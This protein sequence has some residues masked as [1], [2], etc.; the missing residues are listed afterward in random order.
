MAAWSLGATL[1]PTMEGATTLLEERDAALGLTSVQA[2]RILAEVGP[3][4]L[5]EAKR[6]SRIGRFAAQLV[7]LFALLLWAGAG[8]AWLAG[9]PQLSAAIVVVVLVNAIFAFAQEYRAE[10][11]AEALGRMLPQTARVRRDGDVVLL[12]AEEL[13]PGD[14][15]LLEAGDRVSADADLLDV[16]ELRVDNSTLT[17]ESWPVAPEE[18]VFAGTFVVSGR[19]E[20]RVTATGMSTKLGRIAELTQ[21]SRRKQS[22]LELELKRVTRLVA[23]VSAGI[24]TTFFVVAGFLGMGLEER[25]VFAVGVMVAN[26]PEG[27]LPTV[28]LALA[29]ATQRM[30][31]QNALI[32][33]LSSV[34]TL[35]ETTVICT[36]KTGTL[37]ENELTAVRIWTPEVDLEVEG[38][39]Y[40]P[41][42]RFRS[43]G[44]VVQP[45]GVAELLRAGLLC[46]DSRL[47]SG[48]EGWTIRGDPTEGA[49]VVLAEK[50][51]LRQEQEVARLP[52]VTEV[53]FD[54][55]RRR[56]TTVHA[57][58]AERVAFVKGAPEEILS[59]SDLSSEMRQRAEAAAT[60]MEGDAL[61]VL[62]LAK[63]T[64][65]EE[66]DSDPAQ[67]DEGLE[68]L[69]LVGMHDPPRAEVREAIAR[70]HAAGIRVLM[71][72]GDAGATAAAIAGRIGLI[73]RQAHVISGSELDELDDERLLH[74]LEERDVVFARIDPEQKLRLARVLQDAGEVVA[75]TGDGVNDAPALRE[76]D[77]GVAMGLRGTDVAKEAADMIL[78]DDN[79]A[80]V[81]A[82]IEE[83]R[84]VYDNI[85]RFA[86]YHFCSNVAE[87]L[88]FV[89]WGLSGGSIPLPL[90]VMQVLA[91]DLGTDMLPA[92]ALGTEK[93]EP[94]TMSRPPRPRG[95]RLLGPRVLARAYGFVGLIEGLL[96]LAAFMF[97]FVL[98][99]WR[100]GMALPSSGAA[101]VQATT[102][103][104]TGV[105]MGQVGAGMAMRTNRR[106]VFSI[107]LFTNRFLL[108]AIVFELALAAA[109]IY[110]PGLNAAFHQAPIGVAEWVFL[111]PIPFVVFGAEEARKAVMRRR[112]SRSSPKADREGC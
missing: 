53:P 20:T 41:F 7:H 33:R 80:T 2:A 40:E 58:G 9:M 109:L 42:G 61:R 21:G 56:M 90:T 36:D 59:R 96:G 73:R 48:A 79:F 100:P 63:K 39:G 64:L 93:A 44:K 38:A 105:V 86:V 75:M 94:G 101:Y 68:L 65:R 54:S 11:A 95:E 30:A 77:I 60:E 85:R 67:L 92:I 72:T 111:A 69:G 78:L 70:C 27:L 24:G 19:G 76:A 12:P 6:P 104:Q 108:I 47:V 83:G 18:R 31:K 89:A 3:N 32:R 52:R 110:V 107:G 99:G 55:Q 8:L 49:L 28:T 102:M 112:A 46:N 13:V 14:V 57:N 62:A 22:P 74:L 43:N 1:E 71:V 37:T 82:A 87:L 98:G 50:G 10:R 34:E 66:G 35:G 16:R 84:A 88:P 106:S 51:G 4:L 25:F 5:A 17:G 81:V 97:S 45:Q 91:I 29:L 23:V 103:T 26:V 15:L